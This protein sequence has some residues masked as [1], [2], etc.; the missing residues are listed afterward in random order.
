MAHCGTAA[1]PE[2]AAKDAAPKGATQM[3][4]RLFLKNSA[5]AVGGV[6]F[7]SS[8]VAC[9]SDTSTEQD[10]ELASGD[11]ELAPRTKCSAAPVSAIGSNHGHALSIPLAEALAGVAKSYNIKGASGHPHTVAVSVA[12]F[13]QLGAGAVLTIQSTVDAGHKHAVKI[14]CA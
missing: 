13:K 14:S 8:L 4:R 3:D 6:V 12:Q 9:A 7:A 10:A 11:D 1:T 2:I 5:M